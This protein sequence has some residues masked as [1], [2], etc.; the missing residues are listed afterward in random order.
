MRVL[1]VGGNNKDIPL[2][3]DFEGWE[4]YLL[5]IDPT[6]NP[7]VCMDAR[8]LVNYDG[9]KFDG[10]YCSHNLE[11]YNQQDIQLVLKGFTHILK[12]QGIIIVC[13]PN[14]KNVLK[15]I[16]DSNLELEDILYRTS[17]GIPIHAGDV[18]FGWQKQI[19]ESGE[20]FFS[21]KWGFSSQSLW[22]YLHNAGF[23]DI[24]IQES[25]LDIIAKGRL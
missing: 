4:Q 24:Q 16:I 19:T 2:H 18:I 13:V 11:H 15:I 6:G 23:G 21:H 22:N 25:T 1:N 12:S 3:P 9:E 17:I 10:I 5:D 20:D 14:L 8:N 7:D